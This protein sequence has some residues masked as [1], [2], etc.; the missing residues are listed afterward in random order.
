MERGFAGI[1]K[2][3]QSLSPSLRF[4]MHQLRGVLLHTRLWCCAGLHPSK[5]SRFQMSAAD[6]LR[7]WN[8]APL[9]VIGASSGGSRAG[10]EDTEGLRAGQ[11]RTVKVKPPVRKKTT[12]IRSSDSAMFGCVSPAFELFMSLC[13]S[14]AQHESSH[15]SDCEICLLYTSPSPR[16]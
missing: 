3:L 4:T 8:V 13:V 7:A 10:D 5:S 6:V 2:F 1:C 11:T 15:K 14:H 9:R 16:D 12:V